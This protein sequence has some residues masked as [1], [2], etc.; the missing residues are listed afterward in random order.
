[1]ITLENLTKRY[2]TSAVVD[3][4]SLT[5]ER[6]SITVIVGTSGSGKSTLLRMINRLVEPTSGRVLIG[7]NDTARE[8]AYL[9]RRRIGYAI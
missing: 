9:V 4:V 6:G 5:V 8:P 7:G 2:G 3:D 1:M